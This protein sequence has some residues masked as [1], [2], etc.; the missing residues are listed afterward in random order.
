MSIFIADIQVQDLAYMQINLF[1]SQKGLIELLLSKHGDHTIRSLQNSSQT[2]SEP[3]GSDNMVH[4]P[5][6]IEAHTL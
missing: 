5:V 2:I 1:L 3:V 4:Y 6:I